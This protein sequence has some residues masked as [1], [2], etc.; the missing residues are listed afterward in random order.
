MTTCPFICGPLFSSWHIGLHL[1]TS[2]EKTR[3]LPV[4]HRMLFRNLRALMRRSIP[5][6]IFL[7]AFR[8]HASVISIPEIRK[9]LVRITT[10]SQEPNYRMPWMPGNVGGGTG[11]GFVISGKRILTNAHVV[12]N[13]RFVSLER[14]NDPKHYIAKVQHIA[15]DCDLAVLT[16]SDSRFFEGT[17]PLPF[18]NKIPQIESSVSVYGYPIGGDRLSVT[19]GVVS[20]IDFQVYSH[21]VADSHLAIQTNAAINPGNSGGPVLQDGKVIGVAFQGYSGDVAQN[22]GYMIPVPVVQRFLKD[23]EDGHYDHYMDLSITTLPLLNPA[24]RAALGLDPDDNHGIYVTHVAS[25]GACAGALKAGDVIMAIDGHAVESD[26]FLQ[27]EGERMEMPEIVERKFKGDTVQFQVLRAKKKLS[28]TVKLEH[29]WPYQ[30]QAN[31]YEIQPRY[32]LFGGLVFQPLSRNF[33]EASQNDDLRV[34]YT[35]DFFNID[36]IYK[37]RPEVV[38]LSSILPDPINTYLGEFRNGIVDEVNGAKI[39]SL[40]DLAEAL[41]KT[42]KYY[43]IKVLGEGRPVVLERSEVEAAHERI[44]NRYKVRA[45]RNLQETVAN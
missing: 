1:R 13:A 18:I 2:F 30:L 39:K 43:V 34:R 9:S 41:A 29:T 21:S 12:S 42:E 16:V 14:E 8:L 17:A 45:D 36:E 15:H 22:T 6:L 31:Q 27:L 4:A 3:K 32:I 5:L 7:L 33:L 35:Y 44:K 40:N 10:T 20:R 11:A 23:I 26:G 24:Q 25:V 37:E 19:T 28:F 38:V